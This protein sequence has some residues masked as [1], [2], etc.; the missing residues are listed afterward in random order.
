M[1]LKDNYLEKIGIKK[2][3]TFGITVEDFMVNCKRFSD[4][5]NNK[6]NKKEIKCLRRKILN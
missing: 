3:T 5:W 6:C 4:A 2:E 1:E